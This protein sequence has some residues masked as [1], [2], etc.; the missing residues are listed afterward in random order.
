MNNTP[1]PTTNPAWIDDDAPEADEAWFAQARPA[2]EVLPQLFTPA[3][4]AQML[5]P[6]RGR[7][8]KQ[9]PKIQLTLRVDADVLQAF[10]AGGAGWQTRMNE[11]LRD[12]LKNQPS[13]L[14]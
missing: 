11:A 5:R 1:A 3:L 10:R 12:W 2:H 14:V 8:A 4:A 7:P 13:A 9:Q 6:L